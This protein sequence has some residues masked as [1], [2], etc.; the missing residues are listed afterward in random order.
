MLIDNAMELVEKA[1]PEPTEADFQRRI[2][3]GARACARVGLTQVQDASG[4]AP[5]NIASLTRLSAAGELPIRIYAT[6]SPEPKNLDE[7]FARGVHIGTGRDLLTVRAIKAYADGALGSRGAALLSDYSD[8]A[9]NR[10]LLGRAERLSEIAVSARRRGWQLWVHAIGDRGNRVALDAFAAAETATPHAPAGGDR[11]RIEHAQVVALED[12]PRFAREGVIA[13]IQ[14]THATSD[15]GWAEKRVGPERIRGAYAWR[16]LVR[17]GARLAG[18]SDFP[19]ES[20]NPILGFYAA[21]TRQDVEGR[22]P[23]G[24]RP[25]ERLSRAEALSLFTTDAAYAAFEEKRRGRIAPGFDADLTILAADPM[26]VAVGQIPAIRALATIV[27]GKL[28]HGDAR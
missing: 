6:V 21:V 22:P 16:T 26:A 25:E 8:E 4:Y 2:L 15:M 17:S 9:G 18:G 11:G 10:G 1:M 23:G 5:Q 28:V 27:D 3:A 24:W 19:V 12:F 13:S 20:E 7:A 14:P